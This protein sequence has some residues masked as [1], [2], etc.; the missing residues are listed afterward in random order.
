VL[1]ILR[2]FTGKQECFLRFAAIP[3]LGTDKPILFAGALGE[4]MEFLKGNDYQFSP[5][6]L[7]PDDR[8]WCLCSD[9]DLMFSI[10]GGPRELVS[11]IL[12]SATLEAL[13]VTQ[14]TRIDSFAPMQRVP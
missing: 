2:Q 1:S 8:N 14:Q 10:V 7:W 12:G 5:E 3:F 6:Y 9:Y 4:V 13:Q 11:S